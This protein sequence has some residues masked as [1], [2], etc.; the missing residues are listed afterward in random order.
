[1][2]YGWSGG[3]AADLVPEEDLAEAS[4]QFHVAAALLKVKES[5]NDNQQESNL[6]YIFLSMLVFFAAYAPADSRESRPRIGHHSGQ[7]G[8]SPKGW[9]GGGGY[10]H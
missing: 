4:I 3:E 8:P 2:W 5:W 10:H 7:N 6:R 9:G 1:M